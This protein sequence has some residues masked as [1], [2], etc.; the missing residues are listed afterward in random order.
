MHWVAGAGALQKAIPSSRHRD[1]RARFAAARRPNDRRLKR[2]R[3]ATRLLPQKFATE[4]TNLNTDESLTIGRVT[5]GKRLQLRKTL[6][7][8]GA[9]RARICPPQSST[10]YQ[11]LAAHFP[12][13]GSQQ[14][15][16][17]QLDQAT[18]PRPKRARSAV[19]LTARAPPRPPIAIQYTEAPPAAALEAPLERLR[20]EI[21]CPD[22]SN[23]INRC[24]LRRGCRGA[25]GFGT[26][27]LGDGSCVFTNRSVGAGHTADMPLCV[28]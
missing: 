13:T 27:P 1:R 3:Q 8:D 9:Y 21:R 7:F 19:R 26:D 16:A 24:L 17:G 2:S 18:R 20:F 11:P 15:P 12:I 6:D 10:L 28:C 14:I 5:F 22:P 25:C 4:I 23:A